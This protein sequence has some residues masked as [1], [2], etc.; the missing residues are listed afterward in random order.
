MCCDTFYLSQVAAGMSVKFDVCVQAPEVTEIGHVSLDI[1]I[2]MET[3]VFRLPILAT[4][5][6]MQVSVE[7]IIYF[8][9]LSII[10]TS[11]SPPLFNLVL[12]LNI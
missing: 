8:P 2:T 10:F 1:I 6:P 11:T 9:P 3:E 12:S 7:N 4:V 5:L